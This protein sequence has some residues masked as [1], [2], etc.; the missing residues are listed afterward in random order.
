M[1]AIAWF[2]A[3]RTA[4]PKTYPVLKRTEI[5]LKACATKIESIEVRH[6]DNDGWGETPTD[7]CIQEKYR[8]SD[9][10][11]K[12]VGFFCH[13][14]RNVSLFNESLLKTVVGR[15][16]N[17]FHGSDRKYFISH[18]KKALQLPEYK[19]INNNRSASKTACF[20]ANNVKYIPDKYLFSCHYCLFTI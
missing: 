5:F 14:F 13:K 9:M 4:S 12:Q 1:T 17:T 6:W 11:L 19:N 2:W 16:Y 7:F 3:K 18:C 15:Y 20:L 10:P 8:L